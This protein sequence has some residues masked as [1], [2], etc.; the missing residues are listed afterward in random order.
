MPAALITYMPLLRRHAVNQ[1]AARARYAGA[2]LTNILR[3]AANATG[4]RD[5]EICYMPQRARQ[6]AAYALCAPARRHICAPQTLRTTR[7]ATLYALCVQRSAKHARAR[8]P[9]AT[10]SAARHAML[11]VRAPQHARMLSLHAIYHAVER[12]HCCLR[13]AITLH[14]PLSGVAVTPQKVK[15]ASALSWRALRS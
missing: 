6:D 7:H 15:H 13:H 9:R 11:R 3:R 1:H 5:A 2:M 4:A 8:A 14:A 12:R 10:H